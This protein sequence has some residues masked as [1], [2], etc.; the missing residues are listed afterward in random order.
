[1]K[2]SPLVVAN[3]KM[4]GQ[5][6]T[7]VV[8]VEDICHQ[9]ESLNDVDIVLCPPFP[10]LPQLADLLVGERPILGAQDLS[11]HQKGAYTGEVSA[12][13][14]LDYN[15]H[16]VIIGHSERRRDNADSDQ[17]IA[18]KFNQALAHNLIPILCV[19]ETSEQRDRGQAEAIVAEQI[20][21]VLTDCVPTNRFA[22]AYEPIWAIGTGN[23]ATPEQAQAM[24]QFIRGRLTKH[25]GEVQALQVSILYGGSINIE[26]ARQ[27][28][29]MTDID[30][31][32]VGGASLK[33]ETFSEV[34]I[35][36]KK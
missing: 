24:H 6:E 22:I 1:M 7:N 4:H 2:P 12:Q 11:A 34:C 26:N 19:G 16:M 8:L 5:R 13:M 18:A 23:S 25:I 14:L 28:F 27:L 21:V 3:W 33:A 17:R 9:L 29:N 20:E 15:C 32:L 30:G 10:F 35:A 36:A 31:G